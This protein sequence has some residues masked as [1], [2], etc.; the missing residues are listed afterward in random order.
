MDD[1]FTKFEELIWGLLAIPFVIGGIFILG[2]FM[3]LGEDQRDANEAH[4]RHTAEM[5]ESAQT[6]GFESFDALQE[7]AREKR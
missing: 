7:F 4:R 6:L 1:S 5:N 3:S 2:W